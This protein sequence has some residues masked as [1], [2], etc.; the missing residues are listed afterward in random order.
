MDNT[1]VEYLLNI[2]IFIPIVLVLIVISLRL[3]KSSMNTISG[4]TYTQ[5]LE[6][7]NLTKDISLYVIKVG[8]T[9]LVVIASAHNT[10]V[11]KELTEDEVEEII[12]MKKKKYEAVDLSKIMGLDINKIIRKKDNGYNK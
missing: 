8:T 2:I 12:K 1:F 10:Q 11:V 9:G 7:F 4:G 3:S 5:V 6:R